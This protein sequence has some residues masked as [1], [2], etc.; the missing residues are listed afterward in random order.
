MLFKFTIQQ[1]ISLVIKNIALNLVII[2]KNILQKNMLFETILLKN[3]KLLYLI[4]YLHTYI[5]IIR[6]TYNR[7]RFIVLKSVKYTLP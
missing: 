3:Q 2:G 4:H 6:L 1:Q 5:I 7:N